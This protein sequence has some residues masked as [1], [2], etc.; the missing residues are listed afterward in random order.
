MVNVD[1]FQF[2]GDVW[3]PC[4]YR[5]FPYMGTLPLQCNVI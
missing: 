2:N 5:N 1:N 3:F 4:P